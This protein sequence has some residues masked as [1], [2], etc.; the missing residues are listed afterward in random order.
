MVNGEEWEIISE[1]K[2]SYVRSETSRLRVPGGWLYKVRETWAV[3][4]D[5]GQISTPLVF[6]P[7]PKPT[8][9][10]KPE[11]EDGEVAAENDDE[12]V[13]VEDEDVEVVEDEE[14]AVE[15]EVQEPPV[16]VKLKVKRMA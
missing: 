9:S 1:D 16:K 10:G 14:V 12:V 7:D 11:E 3:T 15:E 2:Q 5:Y 8:N 13:E 4:E 6:V